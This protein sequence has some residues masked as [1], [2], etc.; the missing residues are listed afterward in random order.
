MVEHHTVGIIDR[1]GVGLGV[2]LIAE[3]NTDK[4]DDDV[5][6]S[7]DDEWVVSDAYPFSGG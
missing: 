1:N 5:A 7:A 4:T 2:A 6:G 3:A